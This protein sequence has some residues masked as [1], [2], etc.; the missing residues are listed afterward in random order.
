MEEHKHQFKNGNCTECGAESNNGR[1]RRLKRE[2]AK[3][4]QASAT[5]DLYTILKLKG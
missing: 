5:V 4:V 3:P 1:R 2:A